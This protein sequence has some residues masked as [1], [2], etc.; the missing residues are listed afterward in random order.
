MQQQIK[1]QQQQK[2]QQQHVEQIETAKSNTHIS[3]HISAKFFVNI[4]NTLL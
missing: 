3:P 1:T 4:S 2:Q